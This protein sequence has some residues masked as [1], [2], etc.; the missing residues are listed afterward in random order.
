MS[1]PYPAFF[2]FSHDQSDN[3]NKS[4]SNDLHLDQNREET[5][6]EVKDSGSKHHRHPLSE[7][8]RPQPLLKPCTPPLPWITSALA[9]GGAIT[10]KVLELRTKFG[11]AEGI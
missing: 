10:R 11:G 6:G 8:G 3:E 2:T 7:E 1:I 5:R 4:K 9:P